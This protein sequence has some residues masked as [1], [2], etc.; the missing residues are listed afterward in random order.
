MFYPFTLSV[1]C[2]RGTKMDVY[3]YYSPADA[4]TYGEER[5]YRNCDLHGNF[6]L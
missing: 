1:A 6:G 5:L 4:D 2:S 3:E